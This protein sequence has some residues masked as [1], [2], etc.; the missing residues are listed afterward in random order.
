MRQFLLHVPAAIN[1]LEGSPGDCH[2]AA[3]EALGIAKIILK[4]VEKVLLATHSPLSHKGPSFDRADR[5]AP[6]P[7]HPPFCL[8]DYPAR[9]S[10]L[11]GDELLSETD[12]TDFSR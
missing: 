2:L 6:P 4:V 9:P 11:R 8:A 7:T 5:L 1:F 10:E 3:S 12:L